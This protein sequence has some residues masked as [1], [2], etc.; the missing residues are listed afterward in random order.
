QLGVYFV[1]RRLHGKVG[2]DLVHHVTLVNYWMPSFLALLPPPF[3]LGP[4]G[5]GESAP[6]P[7]WWSFS[8]R[9]KVYESLRDLRRGLGHLDPFVRFAARRATVALAVTSQTAERLERLGCRKVSV[10]SQVGLAI[11][12]VPRRSKFFEN[13][14]GLFRVVSVGRMLHWK[15]FELG[16]R[17]FALLKARFPSC[18]YWLIGDGPERKRLEALSQRL[19]AAGSVRFLGSI[20]RPQ[21]L[22]MMARC[23]VL[24]NPSL[25]DSGGFVCAEAMA[26]GLP[27]IC[28]DL[29]GPAL[30]VTPETGIK[31]RAAFPAQVIADLAAAM[32]QLA[33]DPAR[34]EHLSREARRRARE[35]FPWSQKGEWL[36]GLYSTATHTRE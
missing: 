10:I 17:A 28:L 11:D 24:I 20:P 12:E 26:A 27:V 7:F 13:G 25:H 5:G 34:R 32:H 3:V 22:E 15:G 21:V 6:R 23:K 18:E 14:D 19:G 4:V 8:M 1:A 30:Q 29:G 36:N 9:G 31:I 16:V 33:L 2:F 35:H